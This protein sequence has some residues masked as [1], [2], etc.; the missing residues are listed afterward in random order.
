VRIAV[1]GAGAVGGYFGARLVEAGEDVVFVARGRTLAAL[2]ERGLRV[3]SAAGDIVLDRV[4]ATASPATVG[5][6]DAALIAVKAWQVAEVAP[7]LFPLIGSITVLLPL[8]NG[9]EAADQLAAVHGVSHVLGGTCR[10]VAYQAAPGHVVH[11][12]VEPSVALGELDNERSERVQRLADT[13]RRAGIAVTVPDSIGSAIWQ[14]FLFIA[15]VSGVGAV[16]RA[17]VGVVR[18][19]PETRALL[20]RAMDEVASL[21]AAR[22]VSLPTDIVARTLAFLDGMPPDSTASMQRDV[23][24]GRPSELEAINGAVVRIAREAGVAV[25]VHEMIYASLLP[26]E[27]AARAAASTR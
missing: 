4:S 9:V 14:K 26:Q 19:R 3:D 12:G 16:T 27:I 5:P 21:A 23:M 10:I 6:V 1:I 17:M 15:A 2:R 25:P 7:T 8:Q 18:A 24:E 13:L 22:G 20:K 11:A